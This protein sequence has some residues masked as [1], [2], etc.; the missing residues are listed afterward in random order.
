M[1][2][3]SGAVVGCVIGARDLLA[4]HLPVLLTTY[5]HKSSKLLLL[6]IVYY[7]FSATTCHLDTLVVIAKLL[8][9]VFVMTVSL[10]L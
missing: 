9:T 1:Q 5:T 10:S 4:L 7:K 3:K 6:M 2:H 8:S